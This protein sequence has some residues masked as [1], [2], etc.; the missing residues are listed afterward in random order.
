[1]KNLGAILVFVAASITVISA[2]ALPIDQSLDARDVVPFD[3]GGSI[4]EGHMIT[5]DLNVAAEIEVRSPKKAATQT[6][7]GQIHC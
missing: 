7:N 6:A 5:I 1:M 2:R 3:D 4:R